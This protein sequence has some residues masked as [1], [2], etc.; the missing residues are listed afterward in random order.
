MNR[1]NIQERSEI[2]GCLVE[3]NSIRATARMTRADKKTVLRLLS[4]FGT[5][6]HKLHDEK[7]RN[8]QSARILCDGLWAFCHAKEN[9]VPSDCKGVLGFGDVWTWAAIC[10]ESKLIVSYHVGLREAQDALH[11]TDDL[12]NV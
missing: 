2:L 1:L 9:N 11:L 7:V 6:C 3:G 4:E 5:A 12:Q 8:V 10:V